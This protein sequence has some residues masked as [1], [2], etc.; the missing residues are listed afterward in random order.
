[1]KSILLV[2]FLVPFLVSCEKKETTPAPVTTPT[3]TAIDEGKCIDGARQEKT[4]GN[5]VQCRECVNGHWQ[6]CGKK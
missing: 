6:P 1:M 5:H 2:A 4:V 3:A